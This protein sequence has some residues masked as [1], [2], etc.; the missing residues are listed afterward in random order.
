MFSEALEIK[1]VDSRVKRDKRLKS[2][3]IALFL[4]KFA[5]IAKILLTGLFF[6]GKVAKS[7]RN[8]R[9]FFKFVSKSVSR[10]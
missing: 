10:F 3:L 6:Y 4:T 9:A 8:F 1:R 5:K 2:A 7:K